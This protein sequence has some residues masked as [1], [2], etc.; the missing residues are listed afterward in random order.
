MHSIT[1]NQLSFVNHQRTMD[2]A[3]ILLLLVKIVRQLSPILDFLQIQSLL[4]LFT[5]TKNLLWP[6]HW[7]TYSAIFYKTKTRRSLEIQILTANL[8]SVCPTTLRLRRTPACT[9]FQ[10]VNSY[11]LPRTHP[12]T[13]LHFNLLAKENSVTIQL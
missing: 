9:C 10:N 6:L 1:P 2:L 3:I 13:K 4:L 8:Q 11:L 5:R 7:L 12:C